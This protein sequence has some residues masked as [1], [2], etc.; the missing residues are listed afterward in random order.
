MR[1]KL[2]TLSQQLDNQAQ[3]TMVG[4]SFWKF[5]RLRFKLQQIKWSYLTPDAVNI[6][7]SY[8]Y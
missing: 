3:K 2:A 8:I 4:C 5:A 6:K 7:E 1:F